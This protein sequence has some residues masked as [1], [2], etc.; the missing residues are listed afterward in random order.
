MPRLRIALLSL[1]AFVAL[2]TA[3]AFAATSKPAPTNPPPDQQP[4]AER[5]WDGDGP[6]G[7]W[8]DDDGDGPGRRWDGGQ[9]RHWDGGGPGGHRGFHGKGGGGMAQRRMAFRAANNP[10]ASVLLDLASC[11]ARTAARRT[12]PRSTRTC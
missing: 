8:D 11:T 4:R 3:A 1:L 2:A 12:S 10:S 5:N 9:G 6:Q 7:G